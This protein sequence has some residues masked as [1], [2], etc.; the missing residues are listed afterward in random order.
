Q[1]RMQRAGELGQV[2]HVRG[3]ARHVQV[4]RL[5]RQRG[6]DDGGTRQV[7]ELVHGVT[8]SRAHTLVACAGSASSPRVSSQKRHSRFCATRTRYAALA[9]MSVIGA[10]SAARATCAARTVVSVQGWPT[11]AASVAAARFTIAAMPP[12]ARRI[13]VTTSP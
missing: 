5:V 7:D 12:N 9:R 10:K 6:A 13:S 4:R 2:V 3:L 11:M 8:P 1:R